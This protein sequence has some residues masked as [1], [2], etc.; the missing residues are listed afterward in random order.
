MT[1]PFNYWKP[2]TILTKSSIPDVQWGP[3]FASE[4][5]LCVFWKPATLLK[6]NFFT[7]IFHRFC[8]DCK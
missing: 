4:T 1:E 8:P 3:E 7:R 6:I 2:L 5:F